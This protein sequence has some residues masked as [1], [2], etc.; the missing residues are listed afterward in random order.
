MDKKDEKFDSAMLKEIFEQPQIISKIL[1]KYIDIS[2]GEIDFEEFRGRLNA[3]KYIDRV[4]LLGCGTSFYAAQIGNYIFEEYATLPSECELADEF[5]VRKKV[6]E[7]RTCVIVLSQS[8]ETSDIIKAVKQVRKKDVFIIALTNCANSSLSKE[9]DVTIDLQAGKERAMAAT[10]SFTAQL[11]VLTLL[12]VFIGR[13]HKM[14]KAAGDVVVQEIRL[15]PDK[16]T[17]ALRLQKEIKQIAKNYVNIKHLVVLGRKYNYPLALEAAHKIKETTYIQA[18]GY[19]AEE[20]Q[21]G[22]NAI[23]EKDFPLIFV[24]PEDSVYVEEA[25]LLKKFKK[26]G[27]SIL[28]LTTKGNK[29]LRNSAD[30]IVHVYKAAEVLSPIIN[31]IPLQM[32]AYYIA[33]EKGIDVDTP[34]NI[35]KFIKK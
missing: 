27:A 35:T 10:K 15:L 28:A 34:R 23:L 26:E 19:S 13:L 5:V 3:L 25:K 22:P 18:E 21:H 33:C 20:F 1:Q 7:N 8:G 12:S 11:A 31:I 4:T 9:A 24:I 2:S 14:S 29:K 6:V 17:K 30:R 32:L 16:L